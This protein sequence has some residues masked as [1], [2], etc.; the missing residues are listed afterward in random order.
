MTPVACLRGLRIA[1]AVA[2]VLLAT[3]PTAAGHGGTRVAA[4]E[5][6]PYRIELYALRV[7]ASGLPAVDY[8]VYLTEAADGSPVED[9][10][11]RIA[12]TRASGKLLASRAAARVGNGY[13]VIV[14]GGG[15]GDVVGV[16][17]EGSAGTAEARLRITAAPGRPSSGGAGAPWLLLVAVACGFLALLV[18][19]S[20]RGDRRRRA[21]RGG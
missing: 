17:V 2:G 18:V 13:D 20:V 7:S 4:R 10:S 3:A 14:P 19:V 1:V 21:L 11:V 16:V 15:Q 12:V 6:G 9:A 8:T 5:A